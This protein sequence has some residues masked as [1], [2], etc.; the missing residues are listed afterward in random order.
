MKKIKIRKGDLEEIFGRLEETHRVI[1]PKVEN[2]AVVL[3][4]IEFADLP[5]GVKDLQSP[6]CYRLENNKREDV[7]FS[8]SQGPRSFKNFLSPSIQELSRFSRTRRGMTMQDISVEE[9]PFAFVGV[10]AC[11]LAALKLLDQVFL[12][13]PVGDKAYSRR[14]RDILIIAVNCLNPGGNCFCDSMGTGPEATSGF[15]LSMTEIGG[16]FLIEAG[17][18]GGER[19]IEGIPGAWVTDGDLEEKAAKIL[20]CRKNIGKSMEISDLPG[21]LYRNMEHPRWTEIADRDLECGNCTM[22]CPTCF[23]NST[24]DFLPAA[25]ISGSLKEWGGV[26]MRKWDSCFSKNFA[27]V[28]GGNFRRSRRA[29][30]RHWMTHKLA[31]WIDQFGSP[32]CVGCGRCITWCPVGLDISRELAEIRNVR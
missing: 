32:G 25:E 14:R 12:E 5:A 29:R 7:I 28:H 8:F 23:C 11:D 20:E 26:R 19:L 18:A 15:D 16:H 17:T 9:R 13:G 21:V 24:Y 22:V 1:G 3:A 31:Y 2:S 27:R 10:R 30:Y 4:E 6:G